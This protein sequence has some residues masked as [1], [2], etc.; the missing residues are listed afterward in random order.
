MLPKATQ[1]L[2]DDFLANP[3]GRLPKLTAK[4]LGV[5]LFAA[6]DA[7]HNTAKPFLSDDLYDVMKARLA[8][9]DPA[10]PYLH[11][12]G[13]PVPTAVREA[14]PGPTEAP[15]RTPAT[16]VVPIAPTALNRNVAVELPY[17]MGSLDKIKDDPR[18]IARFVKKYEGP[19]MI[20][21]KLDGISALLQ[22]HKGAW[23]FYTRGDGTKGQNIS[24]LLPVIQGI[25]PPPAMPTKMVF[26]GE[27][28][29]SKTAWKRLENKGSNARNVVAGT[30]N[31]KHPDP[32]ILSE[33]E[34]RV[35]SV[36][37]P[38][39]TP[40]D[41]LALASS[42]GF[43]VVHHDIVD[44]NAINVEDLTKYLIHRREHSPFEVDGI[45][46]IHN[47]LHNIIAG[48]NPQHS[49]AFKSILTHEEAEVIISEVEWNASKDGYL[50]PLVHFEPVYLG[51]VWIRK[52]NGFNAQFIQAN[53]VGPGARI[54]IIRSGDVIPHILR[55]ISPSFTGK[56]S[57]PQDVEYEWND[58]H[59]EIV[60]KNMDDAKDVKLKRLQHFVKHLDIK[61]VAEG[62]LIKLFNA[63]F[64]T[65]Q[66]IL[67]LKQSDL[68]RLDGF[69]AAG[70]AKIVQSIADARAKATCEDYMAAS[71]IFGR[72]LG[73]K[74]LKA[75][76]AAFPEVHQYKVPSKTALAQPIPNV[77]KATIEKFVDGLPGFFKFAKE[78]GLSCEP[79]VAAAAGP[80]AVSGQQQARPLTP[81]AAFSRAKIEGKSF[82]FTG[83]RNKEWENVIESLG[84]TVS[85]SV[86]KKT[87]YVIAKDDSGSNAK[88]VK[89][90]TLGVP[91]IREEAFEKYFST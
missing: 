58:T 46:V 68:L 21:D 22:W 71:T 79:P 20:S 42:L 31:A 80:A 65:M 5:I 49:F 82:V 90:K 52:A 74:T 91:I 61:Y 53:A 18:A 1:R 27:L 45:V 25:P 8:K 24:H 56:G 37:E 77:G 41:G 44:G 64:D 59:I 57:F 26:R 16:V 81:I 50:K 4:Q 7:Y 83:F 33:L 70:A 75:L 12:V 2:I 14:A 55:V 63:G 47:A 17:F 78:I 66:K 88:V 76:V 62:T 23:S 6:A 73:L 9:L 40:Q 84:G 29:L 19:F 86:S 3:D 54:I 36:Y 15:T 48:K 67:A 34:Y 60:L 30:V 28:I 89:A 85:G 38:R 13:A 11:R 43:R 69:A 72:G 87:S 39:L 35:Y 32:E 51:H 10:H